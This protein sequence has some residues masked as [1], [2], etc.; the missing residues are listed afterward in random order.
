VLIRDIQYLHINITCKYQNFFIKMTIIFL[1]I[2]SYVIYVRDIRCIRTLT[3]NDLSW[4]Y[5]DTEAAIVISWGKRSDCKKTI[6]RRPITVDNL[7]KSFLRQFPHK[8][9]QRQ[10]HSARHSPGVNSITILL[11]SIFHF[12]TSG[13]G[14]VAA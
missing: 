5:R 13:V 2:Y 12:C 9:L 8:N 4:H 6:S 14:N 1:V 10:C 3:C 11:A 7:R